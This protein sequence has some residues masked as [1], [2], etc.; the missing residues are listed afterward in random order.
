[1]KDFLYLDTDAISSIS[2]QLFEGNVIESSL[3][4]SNTS[5]ESTTDS[6][7]NNTSDKSEGKASVKVLS[8][9][10]GET[11]G[12]S[13]SISNR[14]DESETAAEST[15]KALDDFIYNIT[16]NE[17]NKKSL[18]KDSKKAL[19]FD[20]INITG[21]FKVI[22]I[23]TASRIFDT[24]LLKKIPFLDEETFIYPDIKVLDARFKGVLKYLKNPGSNKRP[25]EFETDEDAIEFFNSYLGGNAMTAL[26]EITKHLDK[27]FGDKIILS[28]G[29]TILIGDRKNLKIQPEL[30][31]LVDNVKLEGLCRKI[32]E[33]DPTRT[34][35]KVAN[36]EG[37]TFDK[38]DFIAKGTQGVLML[39]LSIMLGLEENDTFEIIQP[40][41]LEYSKVSG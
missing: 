41:G 31:S 33:T 22:D 35:K 3:S 10:I 27:V 11:S 14:W 29:N 2:A 7:I 8:L 37:V 34:I 19:Q 39:F 38:K 40:I 25:K 23:H 9:S 20:F 24:D 18:I 32:N 36:F 1:M 26:N 4:A 15:K 16:L 30:L 5:S 17:L 28:Q 21:D 12:F 6:R 13:D